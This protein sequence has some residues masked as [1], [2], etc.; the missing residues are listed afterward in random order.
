M[1]FFQ[2]QNSCL[3]KEFLCFPIL[4]ESQHDLKRRRR[5][6]DP[7]WF[8]SPEDVTKN[9]ISMAVEGFGMV[10]RA[11][12][13]NSDVVVKEVSVVDRHRFLREADTCYKLRHANIVTFCGANH[14]KPP[15]FIVSQYAVKRELVPYLQRRGY[16]PKKKFV[17]GDLKGNN[18][19]VSEHGTAMLIDFGLSFL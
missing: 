13:A 3:T 10:Y 16:L 2:A 4:M 12:W 6:G 5:E 14:R 7:E 18:I 11:K 17:H 8:I 9:D 1:N 15:Y 19:V